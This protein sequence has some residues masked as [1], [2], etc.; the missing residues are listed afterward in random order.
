MKNNYSYPIDYSLYSTDEII[1]L[2][3]FFE[4]IEKYYQG[5]VME[6]KVLAHYK[7]F[8][9]LVPSKSDRTKMYKQFLADSGYD[10]YKVIHIL[11]KNSKK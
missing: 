10:V 6:E 5:E 7:I 9:K 8:S 1:Q 11:T 4:Q 2:I 3:Q